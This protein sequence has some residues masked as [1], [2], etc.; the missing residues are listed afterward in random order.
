MSWGFMACRD[1]SV[2][3]FDVSR[4]PPSQL[5]VY[6]PEVILNGVEGP[7]GP[8]VDISRLGTP[9]SMS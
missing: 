8:S 6:S 3:V 9:T 2:N 5:H 7:P 1:R 4:P